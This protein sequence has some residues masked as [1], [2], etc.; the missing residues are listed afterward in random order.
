MLRELPV[1]YAFPLEPDDDESCVAWLFELGLVI[2][3]FLYA[4]EGQVADI[5]HCGWQSEESKTCR[6]S[7]Y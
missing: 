3:V 4:I 1:G 7:L 2:S 5:R 6:I